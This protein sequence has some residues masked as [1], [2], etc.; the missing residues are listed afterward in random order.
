VEN[1]QPEDKN[2]LE[3]DPDLEEARATNAAAAASAGA[4]AAS[5][6]GGSG[7]S[8]ADFYA[9]MPMHTY[10]FAPIG[11]TWPAASVNARFPP[12]RLF[13]ATGRPVL[14]TDGKPASL[15]P[16]VWLDQNKPVEQMTWAPGWPM[17][18]YDKLVKDGEFIDRP[19]AKCFNHYKPPDILPGDPRDIEPWI[20]H[21]KKIYPNDTD[22][23]IDFLAHRVQRPEEKIN[24]ALVLAGAPG[25]GKDSIVEPVKPGVG[26]WNFKE[27]SPRDVMGLHNDFVKSVILR[28]NEAHDLGTADRFKFYEHMKAYTAA[29]PNMLRVNEKYVPQYY[30]FNRCSVIMT[31]NYKNNGIYLPPDDRRHYVAWSDEK[32]ANFEVDYWEKL[33]AFYDGGGAANVVAYLTQRDIS[34]FNPKA[35]PGKTGTFWEIVNASQPSENAELADALDAMGNPN[36]VTIQ[37]IIQSIPEVRNPRGS[38]GDTIPA[39]FAEWLGDRRN[40]RVIPHR[41]EECGYVAVRNSDAKDG[42]WKVNGK[43]QVIYAKT[44][45]NSTEPPTNIP[46]SDRLEAAKALSDAGRRQPPPP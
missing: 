31:T 23:I 13:D 1:E 38:I 46:L 5:S 26:G 12:V 42:L 43:R 32:K 6:A 4:G 21:V 9:F 41:F 24:H 18:I 27:A 33:Y 28:I 37:M 22:H 15:K 11:T 34:G 29:P 20:S 39:P 44:V 8:L 19:G 45:D 2:W 17:I 30:I 35:P 3:G 25:I 7:V 10:I 14:D 36:A 40:S 16:S